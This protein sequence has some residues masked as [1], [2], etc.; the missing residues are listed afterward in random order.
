[1]PRELCGKG[2]NLKAVVVEEAL[3]TVRSSLAPTLWAAETTTA[4][5]E[6]G[7]G[8]SHLAALSSGSGH[9]AEITLTRFL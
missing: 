9:F 8:Q 1:M 7:A 5:K 4:L 3:C 2:Q 6:S